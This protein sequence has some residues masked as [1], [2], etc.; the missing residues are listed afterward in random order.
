MF[1][2]EINGLGG[3]RSDDGGNLVGRLRR[4]Q[5]V[6]PHHAF[7]EVHAADVECEVE[8]IHVAEIL[9]VALPKFRCV[10]HVAPPWILRRIWTLNGGHC[11]SPC[12]YSARA[13]HA[14]PLLATF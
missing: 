9:P 4:A 7:F 5:P 13:R 2:D 1:E 6:M 3:L 14:V 8:R 11:D 10:H 12:L